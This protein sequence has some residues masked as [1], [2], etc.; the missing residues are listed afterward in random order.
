MNQRDTITRKISS[1]LSDKEQQKKHIEIGQDYKSK[2]IALGITQNELAKMMGISP[3]TIRNFEKG[4]N[5][6]WR[7]LVET[8]Y[9]AHLKLITVKRNK[10]LQNI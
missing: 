3:V 2:R 7:N 4:K 1:N 5:S 6:A 9:I 8:S 10:I